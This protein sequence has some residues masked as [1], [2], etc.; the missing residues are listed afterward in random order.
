MSRRNKDVRAL[1]GGHFAQEAA[2]DR[3]R[4][5][6]EQYKEDLQ[7]K[8]NERAAQ[9]EQE[10]VERLAEEKFRIED[11]EGYTYEKEQQELEKAPKTLGNYFKNWWAS[12][13]RKMNDFQIQDYQGY[14]DRANQW[15][16][17]AERTQESWEIEDKLKNIDSQLSQLSNTEINSE[18]AQE[19]SEAVKQLQLQKQTLSTRLKELAPA[20]EALKSYSPEGISG[21]YQDLKRFTSAVGGSVFGGIDNAA[22]G[23]TSQ[24]RDELTDITRHTSGMFASDRSRAEQKMMLNMA[25]HAYDD[26]IKEWKQGVDANIKDRESYDKVDRWFQKR[27]ENSKMDIFDSDTWLYGMPGL[28]AG[29]TSGMSKI[30]PAMITGAVTG[31]AAAATGGIA[32]AAIVAAGAVPTFGLNYGA[33]VGENNAEVAMA[34][35]E[36]LEEYLQ[37]AEGRE[38]GKSLYDDIVAEGRKKLHVGKKD[39][40]DKEVFEQYRKGAYTINNAAANKK[41]RELAVGIENQMQDDMAATTWSA[42]IETVLQVMPIGGALNVGKAIRY[43][44]LKTAG[45]REALRGVYENLQKAS[46]V[47]GKLGEG[48]EVGGIVSPVAGALYAPIHAAVS[49]A[50]KRMGK[51][52]KGVLDDISR[53]ASMVD[54]IPGRALAKKFM[55]EPKVRYMKD[56]TGRWI[57]S[58]IEEAIE[59]GKQNISAN[60]YKS[61]EYTSEKIK[62]VGETILDDFLAG[63]KSAALLLG[64]PF[65]GLLSETDRKTLQEMKG[66]LILGG[67]QTS[68]VNV[69]QSVA[70]YR[71][72]QKATTAIANAILLDKAVKLDNY[73]KAKI[74]AE[75]SKSSSAYQNILNAF[76]R[77]RKMN[78]DE[79]DSTGEYGIAPERITEEIN[80]FGEVAKMA[81][82]AYTIKQAE[83]QGIK[84]NTGEYNE[85]VGAK[86]MAIDEVTS[87]QEVVN[88]ASKNFSDVQTELTEAILTERLK[89]V[90]TV[91]EQNTTEEKPAEEAPNPIAQHT[92]VEDYNQMQNVAKYSA[93]LRRKQQLE[94]GI[95]NAEHR[96]HSKIK[97]ILAEQLENTNDQIDNLKKVVQSYVKDNK[98]VDIDDV[99]SIEHGLVL[100]KQDH[101]K[102]SEAYRQVF[103]A[104]QD[105]DLA[106]AQYERVVGKAHLNGKAVE[107][108]EKVNWGEEFDNVTFVGGDVKNVIREIKETIKDDDDLASSIDEDFEDRTDDN[109]E[110][111]ISEQEANNLE[112]TPPVEN[113]PVKEFVEDG[114]KHT[115]ETKKPIETPQETKPAEQP[116]AKPAENKPV[117]AIQKPA[118]PIS[119]VQPTTS[120][121]TPQNAP[122]Q[123]KTATE[124]PS[125]PEPEKQQPETPVVR[126]SHTATQ[127]QQTVLDTI[128]KKAVES[129]KYVKE[130]T[131]DYYL[132]KVEGTEIKM[133]RVHSIMPQYWIGGNERETGAFMPALQV[134]NVF[135]NLARIF[136][137]DKQNLRDYEQDREAIVERLW[138]EPAS[139][140]DSPN[141]PGIKDMSKLLYKDIY[142]TKKEFAKTIDDL[143]NIGST[144]EDLGWELSTDSIV[145]YSRLKDGYVAGE[146]DMLAVDENGDIHIIDFKTAKQR[147][148]GNSPF[149]Y[150]DVRYTYSIGDELERERLSLSEEDFKAGP[151]GK[152]LSKNARAFIK[153]VRMRGIDPKMPYEQRRQIAERNRHLKVV[154]D[155]RANNGEG[156]AILMYM[157]SDYTQYSGTFRQSHEYKGV[158][159]IAKESEYSDQLT[160]YKNLVSRNLANV[161]DLEVL[162]FAAT[163]EHDDDN[164][165][166]IH[167]IAEPMRIKVSDSEEMQD[168]FNAEGEAPIIDAEPP[169]APTAE[170]NKELE[171]QIE[172]QE[173]AKETKGLSVDNNPQVV[174]PTQNLE[175]PTAPQNAAPFGHS[176]LNPNAVHNLHPQLEKDIIFDPDFINEVIQHGSIEVYTQVVKDRNGEFPS[177]YVDITYKGKEYKH[178]YVY[179]DPKLFE[180]L[181]DLEKNKQPGQKIVAT[182]ASRTEGD[183]KKVAFRPIQDSDLLTIPVDR[184]TFTAD[185]GFGLVK[186][187]QLKCFVGDNPNIEDII[188]TFTKGDHDDGKWYY[189]KTLR[190][191]EGTRK[192]QII[193][194]EIGRK[195]LGKDADFIID[196]LKNIDTLRTAY[197]ATVKGKSVNTG[198]SKKDLLSLIMPYIDSIQQSGRAYALLR[199]PRTPSV[200]YVV[201][202]QKVILSVDMRNDKSIA[203]FKKALGGLSIEQDNNILARKLGN[204]DANAAFKAAEKFFRNNTEGITELTISDSIKLRADDFKSGGISGLAW[205]IKNG[206]LVSDYDGLEKPL[207]SINDI[208]YMSTEKPKEKKVDTTNAEKDIPK[209]GGFS[210][211]DVA[212]AN[213]GGK[214]GE[215]HKRKTSADEKKSLLTPE[216]IKKH[217]RPI[218]GDIVD[219][220]NVVNIITNLANDPRTKDAC[221][222]GKASSDAIT[223]YGDAFTGVDYHEAFHRIFELFVPK[224]TREA[225]YS[226]VAKMQGIDLNN[227]TKENN[228]EGHRQ[229]AEWLADKYMDYR[230]YNISTGIEWVDR[231][232]NF[233]IDVVRGFLH[234][235]NYG[236]YKLFLEINSGKYKN[237]RN[238]SKEN[239]DRFNEMFGELNYEIHQQEFQH[240]ANDPMYEDCKNTAFLCMLLGQDIDVSGAT[241]QNTQISRAALQRGAERL[242][243]KGFDIFGTNVEPAEKTAAQLAMTEILVKFDAVADDMA[244]MMA[245]IAT[246]YRKIMQQE[247]RDDL[248]GGEASSSYDENFFKWSYEFNKF[249]KTTS[250]VKF[251][252]ATILDLQYADDERKTFKYATN[253]MGM[254]QLIPMNYVFNEVL[255]QLW[256]VDTIEEVVYRLSNLALQ[257][258]MY[259]QILVNLRKVIAGV[260]NEDGTT[261]ADNEALLAQLMTTIRSNRHTFMLLRS[262]ENAKGVYD[263]IIQRS[264]ADYNARIF[265]LQWSQVLAKGGSETLKLDKYGR[266][267]FNPNNKEAINTFKRISKLFSEIKAAVSSG[268]G[269]VSV[270]IP[271][272]VYPEYEYE[273]SIGNRNVSSAYFQDEVIEDITDPKSCEKVKVAIVDA[274]NRIGINMH[275]EEFEYMLT[276]KYGSSDWTALQQMMQSTDQT[277]SI[278]SFIFFLDN[279]VRNGKLNINES[280]EFTTARGKKVAFDQIFSE[281]AFVKE[282]GN[283]KY[284]YR[285][286]HDQ[287]SVLATG[288]NRF[289]EI[290]DNDYMSDV[291]RN[292]N[293]RGK[294][295]DELKQDSYNYTVG[296]FDNF[297]DRHMYGS[298]TL[299]QL[300]NDPDLKLA[301]KHFIGF[302]TDRRG[303]E[304]SDY[305]E[306]SRRE[307]YLSKVGILENDG[308]ISLTLSDKKKYC[309][310]TGVKLPGIDYTQMRKANSN[311]INLDLAKY[312]IS[313]PDEVASAVYTIQQRQDVV[314]QFISYAK[315]EYESILRNGVRL[316]D[317]HTKVANFDTDE[318]CVR[319]SS[320]LGVYETTFDKD[321]KPKGEQ[322]ISF[323]DKNKSWEE[324]LSIA[325]AYFFDRSVDEQRALIGR[326]LSIRAE[327]EL[328]EA[329]KLGL[330]KNTG[331]STKFKS[332]KNV[333]LN[334]TVITA[335]K[336]SYIAA[337]IG[338]T[339]DEAESLAVVMYMN[340]ISNKA[341]MSGQEM[342]RLFSGNPAFYKWRYDD[343]KLIDRTVDEL[344]RLGGLGSTGVNNFIQLTN[345]PLRY[346]EGKYNCAEVDNEMVS[347]SQYEELKQSMYEGAIREEM[348]QNA[349]TEAKKAATE[350]HMEA[351]GNIRA[352]K[353][354]KIKEKDVL[355][356]EENRRYIDEIQEINESITQDIDSKSIEDLEKDYEDVAA[357]ARAKADEISSMYSKGIDVA[358]G[359]AYISDEMCEALL[360][361]EGAYSDDIQ[362]AFRILRG[363]VESDYLGKIDA[364]Q[365]V[366]TSVIGNQKYTA[367]GRRLQ[368][369]N[370]VP[371]YHKMAL[372]PIF[373]CIA[374]GKMRNIFDKMKEQKID[375]LLVNSAV[376]VGSQGSK[377]INWSDYRE[378]DNKFN[379]NNYVDGKFNKSK[380]TFSEAFQFDPYECEFDY[381]RKQLNTDPKE[382][383]LLRMGTQMQKIVFS[384]LMPGREYATQDGEKKT[385]KELLERIMHSSNELSN[386]GVDNVNKRFFVTNEDGELL[387]IEGNVIQDEYDQRG[388][389]IKARNS[390]KRVL[391]IEKFSNEV[392]KMMSDRGADKNIMK[393]LEIVTTA[394]TNE[395]RLRVPLGAIS[396]ANWL[397]SVLISELNKEIV[398]VNTPGAFFIQRSAWAMEGMKMYDGKKSVK[399]DKSARS[400][401]D[402]KPL[403]MVNEEGSMDCVLSID[404]FKSIIP[405]I[406]SD[407]YVTEADP[408]VESAIKYYEKELNNPDSSLSKEQINSRLQ[409]LYKQKEDYIYQRGPNGSYT[410]DKYGNPVPKKKM[411]DMTFDEARAW[412]IKK[413]IIGE[414]AKANIVA[415]RIPTQAQSS[416]H[417]LRCVDVLSVVRD[418]VILPQEFTKI[419]GS[420]FDIDK[421]G[422]SMLNFDKNGSSDFTEGSEKYYQNQLIK[423]YITL[424]IDPRSQH[425]LHRPI[426]NDTK[427][428]KDVLKEIEQASG[429]QEMPYGFYSLSTQTERKDDYITGKI[430]IGPFA[431]NN[432][433]HILTMLYGVK[434]KDFPGS[435]M[436]SLG[437]T[438]LS[439]NRDQDGQSIMSWLS[440]LIN[441]HVDIAKDPYISRLNVGPFTYN[442]VNTL[443]RTGFG[444]KTFYLTT[445]PIMKELAI[446]YNRASSLYMQDSNKSTW[447]LQQEAVEEAAKNRF[448]NVK[449]G[450]WT[451]DQLVQGMSDLKDT[452]YRSK[453]NTYIK[454]LFES[455]AFK[456]NANK[457]YDACEGVSIHVGKDDDF[458]DKAFLRLDAD[459]VQLLVYLSYLQIDPYAQSVSNLVK[460]SKIDTKKHG[461][462]YIEQQVF[463]RG[464]NDLFYNPSGT[465]LFEETGLRR[466][467]EES[468]I[469]LKTDNAI[470]MTKAILKDQFLQSSNAFDNA[471]QV[472]L[473]M[474]Q[475]PDSKSVDLWTDIA[476]ILSASVK[477]E[478]IVNQYAKTLPQ[479]NS[480]YI[481][482]LISESE[483]DLEFTQEVN[484]NRLKVV[485]NPKYD[486]KTYI[487][488]AVTMKFVQDGEDREYTFNIIGYDDETNELVV[489]YKFKREHTGSMHIVGGKNTIYDRFMSLYLDLKDDPT[490]SDM[491]DIAGEP[492]NYLLKSLT[493]GKTFVYNKVNE[494]DY[495]TK[496]EAPDT[497]P[498]AKFVKLFNA[499]DQN[500]PETNYIIDAWD[501]LLHDERHPKLKQFAEDLVVY[502]FITSGDKGGF[503][504]FFKQVPLSWRI[505]SGYA[506]YIYDKLAE[507]KTQEI[508]TE[509]LED[510]I[511]N[512]WFDYQF[513][514][515]YQLATDGKPNF[516]TYFNNSPSTGIARA[517]YPT[518]VA[519]LRQESSGSITPTIDADKAPMYIKIPRRREKEAR[520]SQR[521]YTVY[522]LLSYGM[523][524][525]ALHGTDE[526]GNLVTWYEWVHY[527]IYVKVEPKGNLL[528]QNY[529][530]TEYM[531]EDSTNKEYAP[532][533]EILKG[534]YKLGDF[535]SQSTIEQYKPKYGEMLTQM[536]QDMNYQDVFEERFA[537]NEADFDKAVRRTSHSDNPKDY[538]MQ[539]GGANGADT[540]WG[541]IAKEFGVTEQNHWYYQE[542]T[543][544]GNI[545]ISQQDYEEGRY[546]VAEAAK[547]NWG[548]QYKTMK[549]S[550]LIRN[551]AQ[552]K[553]ADSVFAIGHLV[554]TGEKLFPNQQDDTRTALVPAVQG[555]TGYAVGMAILNKVPVYV[556]DQERKQWFANIDGEW[557]RVDTPV[558][559]ERFAGIG[560]RQINDAGKQAIRDV[561]EK[562]FNKQ[563]QTS[564]DTN[565]T[566]NMSLSAVDSTVN[567]KSVWEKATSSYTR[568]SVQNDPT[569]LYIFTDNT[570]RTSGGQEYGDG[571]YKQKYG[572]GGFGSMN[573]PTTAQIRGLEN[574]APISTMRYFY[575]AHQG[576]SVEQARW[577]D[578]DIEEFKK[579]IDSEI[580]D[581]KKLWDSGKFTKIVSPAGDGFFNSRIAK[582]T[583][584]SDIGKYL[585]SK[586]KELYDYVNKEQTSTDI[587]NL[588]GKEIYVGTKDKEGLHEDELFGEIL[589]IK[590][591]DN[592]YSLR[593]ELEGREY[594][595]NLTKDFEIANQNSKFHEIF[596][597]EG[598]RIDIPLINGVNKQQEDPTTLTEEEKR[599]A[600]KYKKMCEGE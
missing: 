341:I 81:N 342:E 268:T 68:I 378:D 32:G 480:T 71:A 303:D 14:I 594:F 391:D 361:M 76:D 488:G 28:L 88:A 418:T 336:N 34:Y 598:E 103:V 351:L 277:D 180:K 185:G 510:A 465:G 176:N 468:Y 125:E 588:V 102:L 463:W 160:A 397:E 281:I 106:M 195:T 224:A 347:S 13:G 100:N 267:V 297:G 114:R 289:Y 214:K 324:N 174:Q 266:V 227:S 384:N 515:T 425:I 505:E 320:L 235:G 357:D 333:G 550:R 540:V 423:D 376:K 240:I 276:H 385:G 575:R 359:G 42:G 87:A 578:S 91:G 152:G 366:M 454:A 229:V 193:P 419:T 563:K 126:Q 412:L 62:S 136:L 27:E 411:R 321:G 344:K 551:W 182:A 522:K 339:V 40:T 202:D 405:Q 478:F 475:R 233:I 559:T 285:H 307:D 262:V 67:L 335:I 8:I 207:M 119:P 96:N 373:D 286:A 6:I 532:N 479:Y 55:R 112:H 228:Y 179:A 146:T 330:I 51:M 134:G 489:D 315:A 314:D 390:S 393:A 147:A 541:E 386:I 47:L 470:S 568:N 469:R 432:N 570:D 135:D 450:D 460:F 552:V 1:W 145:W 374:T 446:A 189:L 170:E 416:I 354:L 583:K 92:S 283:W 358:D 4:R 238:A 323:N 138:N 372:F 482:D 322:Y 310:I 577:K 507:F 534:L 132:I 501:Q 597:V 369:G 173:L 387:D 367:F 60:R 23:K 549:D 543:P 36:R 216:Q 258:P 355:I 104:D 466:M 109:G 246:D 218:L 518:I 348:I 582:I 398:D 533:Q 436:S 237:R 490:Y 457:E 520:D 84:P 306:I 144:Y 184:I 44:M 291:L 379:P 137:G 437:L 493:A 161:V 175:A 536:I 485:G 249:D 116:Q 222:V 350:R 21:A 554:N 304:G 399:G 205:Y 230:K 101:D 196:C 117:E 108:N 48:Y 287:L 41:M 294:W 22:F 59:E 435:I 201:Q 542:K 426:D 349:L 498:T 272:Y 352:D 79:H 46:G 7:K 327:K 574:A 259:A 422:L 120:P 24:S 319:F 345:L 131:S 531:R 115:E 395:K 396:N 168:M 85:F 410:I 54:D 244:A 86:Q 535:I 530:I 80:R 313:V 451:F 528:T 537:S 164:V 11:P 464:F 516:I 455:D 312:L 407:E 166:I 12:H 65:E 360:R 514:P 343:G 487:G 129:S 569:T 401:Y 167:R 305:F 383:D 154:W 255:S 318:Q 311:Y 75:A 481:R 210:L 526:K 29:S 544:N 517:N 500:G 254:P 239:V 589:S 317:G 301:L 353:E 338:L 204:K 590:E 83:A 525:S 444:K 275:K 143:Y 362:E 208:G 251:F 392:R 596:L 584:Q 523:Q 245:N 183:I 328:D 428:L 431:L 449:I 270:S 231:I 445:Q 558:L 121:E 380:P 151:R 381:L 292:L 494:L 127:R 296:E 377:P 142:S 595:I 331:A 295:F 308:M 39:M 256:D 264:D 149:G 35:N 486:L 113:D 99:E 105:L 417:A 225:L 163:Y 394:G 546:K 316:N 448:E 593:V 309:Y 241:V 63:S 211:D 364:Y 529:L 232:V 512:N 200:F 471:I 462:S 70:P 404:F 402:G 97:S 504:K 130:V 370:S 503:T 25:M 473:N 443:I 382:E 326:L 325:E 199:D 290:S 375:M 363:E 98:P 519:A 123:P 284:E 547:M 133:P 260:T 274:F 591:N 337:N 509:Q 556:F 365:K 506:D 31:A 150:F 261:N 156:E 406:E 524:R 434:F 30:L 118:E 198:I 413:G 74:Y 400:L 265:P 226:K 346:R 456:N 177:M 252:F 90:A 492:V 474:I 459:Q 571:W 10:S 217:L 280:G 472:V 414:N 429:T 191:N 250:R 579:V 53:T 453:I 165:H 17:L 438:D 467:A 279:I 69:A 439:G 171:Q 220:P 82:D 95:A 197:I 141:D 9:L 587:N 562:T 334:N 403:K 187:N 157:S 139:H 452:K 190:R 155:S 420:D 247:G 553:Y 441:A 3:N 502:S 223:L 433:N 43:Q 538:E 483:D 219:D 186:N 586:L 52:A 271:Q 288:G 209:Q 221:V 16:S 66:G 592:G 159:K 269:N 576:M 389:V 64:M 236:M 273:D 212:I 45:R 33:G 497:Y 194:V 388:R 181:Q 371:Y 408:E 215:Q 128:K 248:D 5:E 424:L 599:E 521:R 153:K 548:Y 293:K 148:D 527:P 58:G 299:Q 581:I 188:Y 278:G 476:N 491:L 19:V 496:H 282:L 162:G 421:L 298:V 140:K 461:K 50:F 56:I 122:E 192:D 253:G 20:V 234:I 567:N 26:K 600:E 124:T 110:E 499:L 427:L 511:L 495:I 539:S 73:N 564:V 447:K 329:E 89:N 93:L 169:A 61:G 178:I 573:N 484:S 111:V 580:E 545:E 409:E 242:K 206:I 458:S 37:N 415:Y 566:D 555:G 430:G 78:E 94:L 49:P 557:K 508:P 213:W 585:Q 356:A 72:E 560:T 243:D 172:K 38:E 18:N 561:F 513:V 300:S 572:S 15:K 57:A 257:D 340:D 477:S 442:L 158:A 263:L 203:D 332:Y 368:N 565:R 2:A 440:A 107:L 77:L 302:K